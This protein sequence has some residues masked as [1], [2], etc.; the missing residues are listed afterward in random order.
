MFQYNPWGKGHGNPP[1]FDRQGRMIKPARDRDG[2]ELV[3][4]PH[5]FFN[6]CNSRVK[7]FC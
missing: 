4:K 7:E 2:N 1:M 6:K 5:I 3:R